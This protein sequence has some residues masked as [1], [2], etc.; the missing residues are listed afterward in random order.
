MKLLLLLCSLIAFTSLAKAQLP[1]KEP[2]RISTTANLRD[3]LL[4]NK[5]SWRN[6]SAGVPDRECVFMPDGTFRH[7]HFTAKFVIKD[8]KTV[9]LNRKGGEHA[10]MT[11]SDDY[12]TFEVLDFDKARRITGK[13]Q[14]K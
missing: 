8:I 14:P 12:A 11:F 9:E 5:W 2:S 7:P 3:F 10:V 6:V 13:R 4:T 1:P